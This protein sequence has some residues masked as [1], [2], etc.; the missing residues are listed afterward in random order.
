MHG[1]EEDNAGWQWQGAES[2]HGYKGRQETNSAA[3]SCVMITYPRR[4]LRNQPSSPALRACH[5]L[6]TH[7]QLGCS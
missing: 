4:N 6:V 5:V 1:Q 2:P 3:S 7:S